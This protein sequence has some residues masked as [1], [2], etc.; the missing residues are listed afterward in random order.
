MEN[1][2]INVLIVF[3]LTSYSDEIFRARSVWPSEVRIIVLGDF[4]R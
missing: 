3:V 2:D 1:G 4:V